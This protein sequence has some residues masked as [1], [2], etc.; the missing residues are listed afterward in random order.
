MA[1][2][3]PPDKKLVPSRP[4]PIFTPTDPSV[5]EKINK[6]KSIFGK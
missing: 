1:I 4:A 6:D 5:I 2:N 3:F